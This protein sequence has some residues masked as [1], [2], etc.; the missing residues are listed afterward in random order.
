VPR[1]KEGR[2]LRRAAFS[3]RQSGFL[4]DQDLELDL[5]LDLDLDLAS[6]S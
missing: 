6:T 2:P 1:G 4:K 5:D 3:L